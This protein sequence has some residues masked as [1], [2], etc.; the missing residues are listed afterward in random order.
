MCSNSKH[1][2]IKSTNCRIKKRVMNMDSG[3]LCISIRETLKK[4]YVSSYGG[5]DGGTQLPLGSG[6]GMGFSLWTNPELALT[7]SQRKQIHYGK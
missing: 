2:E 3:F 5:I 6:L 7:S 4:L 1:H